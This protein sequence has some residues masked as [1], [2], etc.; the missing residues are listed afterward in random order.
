MRQVLFIFIIYYILFNVDK[1]ALVLGNKRKTAVE[2]LDKAKKIFFE[3][4]PRNPTGKIEKP[5]LRQM[6]AGGSVVLQE[7]EIDHK[8]D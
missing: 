2:I 6:Y 5:K 1:N 4:E 8:Q 3:K 7:I